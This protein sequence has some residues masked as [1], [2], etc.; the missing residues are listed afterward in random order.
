MAYCGIHLIPCLVKGG[1][2]KSAGF[3]ELDY[4]LFCDLY[5]QFFLAF[6]PIPPSIV[7][8]HIKGAISIA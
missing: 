5:N 1:K 4:N 8:G 2:G 6:H 3:N 7:H